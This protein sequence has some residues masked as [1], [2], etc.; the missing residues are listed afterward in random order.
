MRLYANALPLDLIVISSGYLGVSAL[1]A[2]TLV[3]AFTTLLFIFPLSFSLTVQFLIEGAL[4]QSDD[5]F[6]KVGRSRLIYTLG[7]LFGLLI[8]PI[9]FIIVNNFPSA[10][11]SMYIYDSK[12]KDLAI[13]ALLTYSYVFFADA[14]QCL[15]LGVMKGMGIERFVFYH[16]ILCLWVVGLGSALVLTFAF[17]YGIVG[18]YFGYGNGLVALCFCNLYYIYRT[19]W[20]MIELQA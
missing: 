19:K 20:D 5:F 4:V 14:F 11:I 13:H 15:L 8:T 10:F 7:I 16:S 1:G 17:D 3:N 12:M 2:M 18:L 6:E 9:L